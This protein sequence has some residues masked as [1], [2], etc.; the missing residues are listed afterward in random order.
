M[1]PSQ[2][3]ALLHELFQAGVDAVGG[4]QATQRSLQEHTLSKH[5]HLVALG[6]AAD[7]MA[8][9]ALSVIGE[10]L[11]SGL[12]VTKH[13]H[14]SD[15]L[16]ADSRLRCIEA[17]HPVPDEGSLLGGK[18][19]SEF[20]AQIPEDHQLVFLVSGGTS[21]LVEHL[22][23]G[24]GLTELKHE[25]DKL[26]ASGAPIGE[27]NRHRRSLSLVKGGKLAKQI[28]CPVLQLL[29]SDVPG[30][31]PGDIGSGLLIPDAA[32]GMPA[33]LP[34]WDLITT[35]IIASS[36]IAQAAVEQ[37]AEAKG[38]VVRQAT[39][40]LH[41][42]MPEVVERLRSVLTAPE[43]S[44]GVY[45]WGGEPTVVLPE[46]PGRGGRN[47][48]LALA[49]SEPLSNVPG[50]S[51][52]VCGTDGTDGPTQDA[53]GLVDEQTFAAAQSAELDINAYLE[54]ADAG[55]CLEALS[56]LVTTGPTG[57]NVMDLAIAIVE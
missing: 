49:L 38:L 11:V 19:L 40:E 17:G 23:E 31:K 45:I 54:R 50:V 37:A 30:D 21:A 18:T 3:A 20:V 5:V 43:L 44:P 48:H 29:I 8:T 28:K 16:K 13:D 35:H 32:T 6:K 39:G 7:A 4:R 56:C 52:L 2:R 12:V 26:L 51:L 47:Q 1:T 41:G 27:M 14:L 55:H 15:A 24:L 53:G 57:T 34:V 36:S 25:T 33:D 9:G 46:N 42:D 22:N 10:R